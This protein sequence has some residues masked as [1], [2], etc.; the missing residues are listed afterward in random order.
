MRR[1]RAFGVVVC[2]ATLALSGCQQQPAAPANPP[3]AAQPAATLPAATV[4]PGP[5]ILAP[6]EG[7]FPGHTFTE[8]D[9]LTWTTLDEPTNSSYELTF[10]GRNPACNL[11][12]TAKVIVTKNQSFSC[13]GMKPTSGNGK[14]VYYKITPIPPPAH[15]PANPTPGPSPVGIGVYSATPCRICNQ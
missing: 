8:G 10:K 9:T 5:I 12:P 4:K 11:P 13:P 1:Y 3:V 2:A 6:H 15:P 14:A 7:G